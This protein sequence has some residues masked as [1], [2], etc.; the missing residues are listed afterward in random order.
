[1]II[2]SGTF[3]KN[4]LAQMQKGY[5]I[6]TTKAPVPLLLSRFAVIPAMVARIGA[7][8]SDL[9]LAAWH[10]SHIGRSCFTCLVCCCLSMGIDCQVPIKRCGGRRSATPDRFDTTITFLKKNGH[11][12]RALIP[13]YPS[14]VNHVAFCPH[15]PNQVLPCI[16]FPQTFFE[17]FSGWINTS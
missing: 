6:H 9:I 11:P 17:F 1:M 12:A 3:L 2:S 14:I 4:K 5:A 8:G 16:P 7:V 15:P 13:Q 10:W